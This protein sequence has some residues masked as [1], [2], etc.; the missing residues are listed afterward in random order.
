MES[1]GLG[2]NLCVAPS[3]RVWKGVKDGGKK[4][5]EVIE[6][7]GL[8]SGSEDEEELED[9]DDVGKC[10][11]CKRR[12]ELCYKSKVSGFKKTRNFLV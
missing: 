2:F 7:T 1:E 6:S 5:E 9:E 4:S 8:D 11:E 10:T 3:R 12:G